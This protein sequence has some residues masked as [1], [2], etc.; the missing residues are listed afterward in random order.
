[1]DNLKSEVISIF[2]KYSKKIDDRDIEYEK[3][4]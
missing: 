4:A 1:M 3:N 2:D